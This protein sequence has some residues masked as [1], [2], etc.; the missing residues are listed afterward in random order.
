LSGPA[1]VV[2][3]A[4]LQQSGGPLVRNWAAGATDTGDFEGS[5]ID[6]G[7]VDDIYVASTYADAVTFIPATI[8]PLEAVAQEVPFVGEDIFVAAVEDATGKWVWR[9]RAG[10][11]GDD[12]S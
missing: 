2:G 12:L 6:F 9:T 10:G 11:A 1:L 7:A 4:T 8:S 5:H 3:R